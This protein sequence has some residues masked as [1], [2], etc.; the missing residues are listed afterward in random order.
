[1]RGVMVG[2]MMLGSGLDLL[3]Q[4]RVDAHSTPQWDKMCKC[5]SNDA[6]RE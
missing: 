3:N 2:R 5:W 4:S 1:M 6:T